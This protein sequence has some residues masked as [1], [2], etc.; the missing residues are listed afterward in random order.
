MSFFYFQKFYKILIIIKNDFI[1]QLFYIKLQ[2]LRKKNKQN[3]QKI[4]EIKIKI[5]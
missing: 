3:K 1:Y 4:S 5:L 2:F